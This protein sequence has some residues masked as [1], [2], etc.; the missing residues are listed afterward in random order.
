MSSMS[1][2]AFL[3]LLLEWPFAVHNAWRAST[4][5]LLRFSDRECCTSE[6]PTFDGGIFVPPTERVSFICVFSDKEADSVLPG[7]KVEGNT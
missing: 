7:L 2:V 3:Q 5:E 4:G 1:S 6:C